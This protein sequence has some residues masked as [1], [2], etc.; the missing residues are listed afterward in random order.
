MFSIYV[1]SE[2]TF[3]YEHIYNASSL[4][5]IERKTSITVTVTLT[6]K[7]RQGRFQEVHKIATFPTEEPSPE[8]LFR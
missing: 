1:W 6:T 3:Y 5:S 8:R 4:F 2:A 7:E